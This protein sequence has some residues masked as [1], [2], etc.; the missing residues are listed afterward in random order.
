MH[1]KSPQSFSNSLQH[2]GP[3][4]T[5]LLCPWDSPGKNT[6]VSC[7][8]CLQ[9]I[10]PTQGSILHPLHLLRW[11]ASSLPLVPPGKPDR[12]CQVFNGFRYL[13]G[14]CGKKKKERKRKKKKNYD[15]SEVKILKSVLGISMMTIPIKFRMVH[16]SLPSNQWRSGTM[17]N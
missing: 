15:K 9:G 13:K 6:G 7:H 16:T 4:P 8:A 12:K 3:Q 2:C 14:K 11:Q 17:G 5:R 1:A 10:F